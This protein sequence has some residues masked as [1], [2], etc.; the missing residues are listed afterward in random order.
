MTNQSMLDDNDKT[1]DDNYK[2][3]ANNKDKVESNLT[4]SRSRAYSKADFRGA[5]YLAWHKSKHRRQW[6]HGSPNPH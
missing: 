1:D 2:D 5:P 3:D 6:S 4:F